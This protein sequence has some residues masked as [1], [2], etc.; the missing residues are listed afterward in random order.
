[1]DGKGIGQ[2]IAD[3]RKERGLTQKELAEKLL[4]TDKAVSKWERGL[5]CPDISLLTSIAD[6]LGVT[7]NELLSGERSESISDE[8]DTAVDKTLIY[9]AKSERR[10][11]TLHGNFLAAAFSGLMLLAMLVCVICDMAVT[12]T[13]TWS[14]YPVS[15]IVFAWLVLVPLVKMGAGGLCPSLISLSIFIFP[16]LFVLGEIYGGENG[17]VPIGFRC[18]AISLVYI[19]GIYFIFK[20]QRTRKLRAWGVV[21]LVSVPYSIV[22]NIS[23]AACLAE[24]LFDVRDVVSAALLLLC[25]AAF[26]AADYIRNRRAG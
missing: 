25:A 1:M 12:G 26:F 15:S 13:L 9:A 6:I 5:S 23:I 21:M 11:L 19:W 17:I 8:V 3:M 14:L 22:L 2:F 16:F 10:K 20:A 4:I 24:P 7:V 18:A